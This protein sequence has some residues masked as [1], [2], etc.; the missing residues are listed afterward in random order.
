MSNQTTNETEQ[1]DIPG[2]HPLSSNAGS[3]KKAQPVITRKAAS[4]R[5]SSTRKAT[6]NKKTAGENASRSKGGKRRGRFSRKQILIALIA[7]VVIFDAAVLSL[8]LLGGRGGPPV[9]PHTDIPT[10]IQG[11]M[12]NNRNIHEI[13][14]DSALTFANY[15]D[16]TIVNTSSLKPI[17]NDLFK[18][19][20]GPD[21]TDLLYDEV[22]VGRVL[23]LNS[24]WD[25]YLNR[26]SQTVF[27]SVKENSAAQTKI[28][29]L[30]AGSMV[31]YHRLA[32]GEIRHVGKNY[33]LIARATYTLTQSGQLDIHDDIF[34]YKL[35]AQGNEMVVIDFEQIAMNL[36]QEEPSAEPTGE[37]GEEPIDETGGEA[38]DETGGEPESTEEPTGETDE[39]AT[40]ESGEESGD[41]SD[42]NS[43]TS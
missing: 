31:A 42:D 26:G 23:K 20:A 11:Q 21:G 7:F 10:L 1:P 2:N 3:K 41:G 16:L 43:A 37:T 32:I 15:P 8:W 5:T 22:I 35:A 25:D 34:V 19:E 18:S 13:G 9:P 40:G 38:T 24:D 33:Y 17:E 29:E 6:S 36:P 39:G 28:A 14:Y 4:R 27:T 30:G 12:A